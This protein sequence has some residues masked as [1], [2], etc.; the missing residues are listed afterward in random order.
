MKNKFMTDN[1]FGRRKFIKT[2]AAVAAAAAVGPWIISSDVLAASGQVNCI[3]WTNYIPPSVIADFNK[4]T[5]I[6]V[7]YKEQSSNEDLINQMKSSKGAGIDLCSPSAN[8]SDQWKNL[9]LLRPFDYDRIPNIGNVNPALTKIGITE[10]NFASK[11]SHWLPFNWGSEG[12]GW[13]TDLYG[14]PGGTPSYGNI[15]DSANRGKTMIRPYSGMLGAGLYME[16]VGELSPGD[17]WK[18]YTNEGHMRR[19]WGKITEFCI[20]RQ[21]QIKLFWSDTDSQ[22]NGLLDDGVIVGQTWDSPVLSL[23]SQGE[24][25]TYQ[26][27][28]EG[29][30]V[31]VDGFAMSAAATNV[32]EAY[33]LIKYLFD[34]KVAGRSIDTHGYNSA[35]LG[36]E[37]YTEPT[38]RKIFT[39]A[40]PGNALAR[41]NPWPTEPKWYAELS[42]EFV[43]KFVYA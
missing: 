42:T 7:N 18:S 4:I 22:K 35:V 12:I 28:K 24:P 30:L 31:W 1:E 25:V 40:Y 20:A 23:K 38:Y 43:N 5:G 41:L 29:A 26:A 21:S 36:A 15:W 6:R 37:K 13:R 19:V 10:W 3:I 34:P 39:E 33:E 11:R 16:T 14:P 2:S 9:G 27:P 32:D 17:V 8:R